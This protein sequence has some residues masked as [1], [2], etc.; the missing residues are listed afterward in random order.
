LE[1][2]AVAAGCGQGG[3]SI[4]STSASPAEQARAP[5]PAARSRFD[6]IG[7]AVRFIAGR[8]DVPVSVPA[9]L[10]AATTL[11]SDPTVSG[12]RAWL[13]LELPGREL[14]TIQYGKSGFDGCGPVH[15]RT[16]VVDGHAAVVDSHRSRGRRF[17]TVVWPATPR[18]LA[19]S[20][21]LSGR[22]S[23]PRLLGFARSMSRA[24][25]APAHR[26]NGC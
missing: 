20:Y 9:R 3:A 2:W 19:G 24:A 14:L 11:A 26:R 8:V 7:A 10:P 17:S 13:H 23:V 21:G 4:A 22:F 15:P 12:G 18:R 6:S 5:A 16:A 1:R 25:A